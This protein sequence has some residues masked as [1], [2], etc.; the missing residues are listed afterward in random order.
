MEHQHWFALKGNCR[1]SLLRF[2]AVATIDFAAKLF[3][4][5]LVAVDSS[6]RVKLSEMSGI[7]SLKSFNSTNLV[8][9]VS[10]IQL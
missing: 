4:A 9:K 10:S 6:G 8:L 7:V 5:K 1:E 3:V 2:M